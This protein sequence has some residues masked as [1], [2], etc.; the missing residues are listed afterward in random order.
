MIKAHFVP[1]ITEDF[2]RLH[3][4]YFVPAIYAQWAHRVVELAEI[5]AGNKVLDVS[6]RTGVLA[7]E[8]SLEIGFT[9]SVTGV[10]ASEQ[11]LSR[12]RRHG[13][14]AFIGQR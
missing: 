10:S 7:R 8:A 9:G 12:A 3:E 11:M 5:D 14:T 1:E 4:K 6:C 13:C 2:V